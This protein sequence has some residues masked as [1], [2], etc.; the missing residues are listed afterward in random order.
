MAQG[1][2]FRVHGFCFE[3]VLKDEISGLHLSTVRCWVSVVWNPQGLYGVF[4]LC[5]SRAPGW[6]G[7]ELCGV[8]WVVV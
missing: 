5:G 2:R 7:S 6:W 8:T 4:F 1:L 3:P